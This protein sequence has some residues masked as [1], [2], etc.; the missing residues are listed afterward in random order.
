MGYTWLH[1]SDQWKRI[2][3][4]RSSYDVY[5]LVD[6]GIFWDKKTSISIRLVPPREHAPA[7]LEMMLG[8]T[9]LKL[10]ANYGTRSDNL[11]HVERNRKTLIRLG[12]RAEDIFYA[13]KRNLRSAQVPSGEQL[14]ADF[15]KKWLM[16][17]S[18]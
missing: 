11:A 4:W 7:D 3:A 15:C 13:N 16:C 5:N 10:S 18:Q 14:V 12:I 6:V 1:C 17:P 2:S 8:D 9:F